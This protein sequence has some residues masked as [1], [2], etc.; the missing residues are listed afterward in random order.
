MHTGKLAND[1]S[2]PRLLLGV[3]LDSAAVDAPAVVDWYTKVTAW[4]SLGNDRYSDCVTAGESHALLALSTY[5]GSEVRIDEADTIALWEQ[6][7][8]FNPST[9][10]EPGPGLVA[11]DALNEWRTTGINGHK[12]AV[13]AAVDYTKPADVQAAIAMFGCVLVGFQ[14]PQTA[15]TQFDNG[16]PWDVVDPDG[17]IDGGHLVTLS[18]YDRNTSMYTC[19]SWGQ[20]QQMT[21]AFLDKYVDECWAVIVPEWVTATGTSPSGLDLHGLGEDFSSLTGQ[22]N[23]FPAPSPAPDPVPAPDPAPAPT[24]A[25]DP[26][27]PTPLDVTWMSFQDDL[28]KIAD[29]I[30]A[31][32]S[33]H[34]AK[35]DAINTAL[36]GLDTA[37]A[38]VRTAVED[39]VTANTT[40]PEPAPEPAPVDPNAPPAAQ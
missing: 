8:G 16:Q 24:P 22:P 12:A 31:V 9:D 19:V 21:Q 27:P 1:P 34:S 13:F 17:G 7:S 38:A 2:K 15:F 11:Q 3:H 25:P 30:T 29:D 20:T 35:A 5:A 18:G 28:K 32:E 23:P 26:A 33:D 14:V 36:Q 37:L 40:P 6:L 4:G 39:L 10:T